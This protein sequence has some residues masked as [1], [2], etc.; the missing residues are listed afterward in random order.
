MDCEVGLIPDQCIELTAIIPV[1]PATHILS[2]FCYVDV[3]TTV[4]WYA[5][6]FNELSEP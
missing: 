5:L 2:A 4:S 6:V 1:Q 3:R